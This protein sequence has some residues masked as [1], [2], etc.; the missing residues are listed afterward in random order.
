MTSMEINKN[1]DDTQQLPHSSAHTL[2]LEG[3]A[4]GKIGHLNFR[5]LCPPHKTETWT[6]AA[7][8][9]LPQ[10]AGAHT[11]SLHTSHSPPNTDCWKCVPCLKAGQFIFIGYLFLYSDFFLAPS[12]CV[13]SPWR[14]EP[15][16]VNP[17]SS[18]SPLLS[19]FL[20]QGL[21]VPDHSRPFPK[22]ADLELCSPA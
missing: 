13:S 19:F 7:G 3:P 8:A 15:A 6:L 21:Q 9:W 2:P 18:G 22:E 16:T 20:L 12:I 17:C 14:Q 1:P 4:Q 5:H 10:I 11:H